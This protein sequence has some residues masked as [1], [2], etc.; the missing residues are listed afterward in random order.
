MILLLSTSDTDL[1]SGR[2]A[3]VGYRLANPA[4]TPVDELPALLAGVD[5]V[6]V[7]ILGGRRMWED[8]VDALLASRLPVVVL[9]GEMEPDAEL[10]ELSTAPGGVVAE[11]HTY[12][13]HGGPANLAELH[14]FLSDALLLTG[15][16]FAAPE[17]TP[18]WGL[19]D[20][21]ESADRR[22]APATG[23]TVAVLYYRAHH[24]SGNTRFVHAL[25]DAIENAGGRALPLFC[26]S[27]RTAEPELLDTLRQADVPG[28]D[29]ARRR[30]LPA[31]RGRCGRQRRGLGR[32]RA[33]RAGRAD[34]AGALPH[35]LARAVGLERR[36]GLTAGR[37]DAG[38][39]PGVRRSADHGAVLVQGGRRG[40]A[41]RLRRRSRARRAGG[42]HRGE[43]RPAAAHPARRTAHRGDAVGLPDQALPDRQRG[44]PRHPGLDGP[45]AAP[46]CA[47]PATTSAR[48]TARELPGVAAQDGDALIHALIAAGG[49]DEDWLTEEQ[50]AGN[51]VRISAAAY[52]SWFATLPEDL[53]AAMEQHWGPPP[54][55]LF[56]DRSQD[57]DGEIVLAA[58]RAGNV[59]VMVQ[60]PRGFGENPIA[61]YHDPDLPP[62]HHYL[63]AY[64][65]LADEFGAD[66]MVHV[67]KHGNLEW[68][69]GKTAG[70]SA[71]CARTP[72]SATCR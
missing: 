6:V 10:M 42:R 20:R 57:P 8:G 67:G 24:V 53:R 14:N 30:R 48:Q 47:R 23:P 29:R 59:V 17:P 54:G 45:A 16:G 5:V 64:R 22:Q 66:A 51:P 34:P 37:R 55:E 60:P 26:S 31:G 12:L 69:P 15:K 40:R 13:A 70:M 9:G 25:S 46:R 7:R 11:A 35:L 27:L 65:W 56:V 38:R 19:L 72:R 61:I 43:A 3:D 52:R 1:L 62:S 36:R 44:R 68:L 33:R 49:Q 2:A 18:N 41:D 39:D 4:R 21:P 71:S 32:R 63:A 58:L 28:S 50:L